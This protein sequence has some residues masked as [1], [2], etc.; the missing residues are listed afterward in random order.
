M[1][2]DHMRVEVAKTNKTL[3]K[4]RWE[5]FSPEIEKGKWLRRFC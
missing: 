1:G 4:H 5:E 3:E 2:S